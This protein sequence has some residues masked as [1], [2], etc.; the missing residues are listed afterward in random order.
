M[1]QTN[2]I[3]HTPLY[4]PPTST[5]LFPS[6]GIGGTHC[7]LISSIDSVSTRTRLYRI[8]Y[9][10]RPSGPCP[11]LDVNSGS[12]LMRRTHSSCTYIINVIFSSI[13]TPGYSPPIFICDHPTI[14]ALYL[15]R[16]VHTLGLPSRRR[17]V[18]RGETFRV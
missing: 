7:Y 6:G 15:S 10:S 11:T 18:S 9:L 3:G 4:C 5:F 12:R 14:T 17:D 16:I 8:A 13:S 1:P 2:P